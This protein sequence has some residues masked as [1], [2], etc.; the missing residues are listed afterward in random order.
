MVFSDYIDVQYLDSFYDL[1]FYSIAAYTIGYE[2]NTSNSTKIH[3]F[4]L[5]GIDV[6]KFKKG[7]LL[8]GLTGFL[9]YTYFIIKSGPL[10]FMGHLKGDFSVGGY[11][12][13]LRF[14]IFSSVLLLFILY[15]FKSLNK[16]Q[17]LIMLFLF[18]YLATDAVIQQQ[19]GSWIRIIVILAFGY[20]ILKLENARNLKIGSLISDYW[21]YIPLL[22][23]PMLILTFSVHSRSY[24]DL[25]FIDQISKFMGEV[26]ENPSI[27]LYGSGVNEGNEFVTAINA[28]QAREV[29]GVIDYGYKWIYPPLNFIPRALWANKPHW[30]SF[31][32]SV[33]DTMDNYGHIYSAPG[34]AETGLIEAFY[35]FAW[36]SPLF[37]FIF[38]YWNKA[39]FNKAFEGNLHSLC[40]YIC[41]YIGLFYFFTQN[42]FPLFIF[43]LYMY[44][45]IY[46][47]FRYAKKNIN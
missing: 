36:A 5:E 38:G 7:A 20:S 22:P 12:Y 42:I 14:F 34:S 29:S 4:S 45:P 9:A 44:I 18:V 21:Y 35:R 30:N 8:T 1:I 6:E 40:I 27:F 28:F 32:I 33:F 11:I 15:N 2:V 10:Y 19:R 23:I 17:T 3:S 31:S 37:F 16:L 46:F 24:A 26:T 39:L 13:E 25:G 41:I 43:T 47:T